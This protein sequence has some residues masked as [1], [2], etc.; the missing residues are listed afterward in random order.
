MINADK[1]AYL[2]YFIDYHK[3]KDPEIGKLKWRIFPPSRIVVVDPA[4]IPADEMQRTYNWVKSWG[5]LGGYP[6][7]AATR[8]SECAGAG[9]RAN[10]LIVLVVSRFEPR[11]MF[12]ELTPIALPLAVLHAPGDRPRPAVGCSKVFKN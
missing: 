5:M 9:P 4:P 1:S 8:R 12:A 3:A 7:T 10:A 6:V 11:S 2:Q